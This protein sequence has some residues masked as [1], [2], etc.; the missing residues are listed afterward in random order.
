MRE[1]WL[2]LHKMAK[3]YNFADVKLSFIYPLQ[4]IA[5]NTTALNSQFK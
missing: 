1:S 3:K 5:L 2:L 4:K